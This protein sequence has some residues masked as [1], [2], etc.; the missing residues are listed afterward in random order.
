MSGT[1]TPRSSTPP[2]PRDAAVTP[3]YPQPTRQSATWTCCA[4]GG[5]CGAP[6]PEDVIEREA[7]RLATLSIY[8][9]PKPY[10]RRA[11][12][13]EPT[14]V[15]VYLN[16][17]HL[18]DISK[19]RTLKS[20]GLG[21]FHS[22]VQVMDDE[23]SFGAP[24]NPDEPSGIFLVPPMEA[25]GVLHCHLYL[26]TT[27]LT[28]EQ[29]K[30]LHRRISVEWAAADYHV[31][32]RN[33]NHFCAQFVKMLS[34]HEPLTVPNWVNRAS[35][36]FD[37]V[38]PK[39]F[40]TWFVCQATQT[41]P[42][43]A[44]RVD[45]SSNV[46]T[47]V[48]W[49]ARAEC[50]HD[51]LAMKYQQL[52][53]LKAAD[54]PSVNTGH[55][56]DADLEDDEEI[57]RLRHGVDTCDRPAPPRVVLPP[58]PPRR[59]S[60]LLRHRI[61]SVTTQRRSSAPLDVTPPGPP[62][63][64]PVPSRGETPPRAG[65]N[66]GREPPQ[67]LPDGRIVMPRP[68]GSTIPMS[69][70]HA[71]PVRLS[72]P[73]AIASPSPTRVRE[74]AAAGHRRS[75]EGKVVTFAESMESQDAP[76]LSTRTIPPPARSAS[77]PA[78]SIDFD[79][80]SVSPLIAPPPAAVAPF[81]PAATVRA[82]PVPPP[83]ASNQVSPHHP[84]SLRHAGNSLTGPTGYSRVSVDVDEEMNDYTQ[85]TASP[86]PPTLAIDR[87]TP[88]D[89]EQT[90]NFDHHQHRNGRAAAFSSGAG[91]HDDATTHSQCETA[92]QVVSGT[93]GLGVGGLA[94][95]NS[96]AGI[97][98]NNAFRADDSDDADD[99]ELPTVTEGLGSARRGSVPVERIRR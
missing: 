31:T 42:P 84:R 14:A 63:P 95:T 12:A 70:I 21:V 41:E 48:R 22:G 60:E 67:R 77:P 93:T 13:P 69:P 17:Y 50:H 19:N 53:Q 2:L 29:I 37:V 26:G 54:R 59:P 94:Y 73:G 38:L 3:M 36:W 11:D 47:D 15:P 30:T 81:A 83:T 10:S 24:A 75:V 66:T 97:T 85:R 20:V 7:E 6:R 57:R 45:H 16:V 1:H 71:D 35:N 86:G 98:E 52:G 87:A 56:R 76:S 46:G 58:P 49:A 79:G 88:V 43:K 28:R 72:A 99:D 64:S 5:C 55:D 82:G 61:A 34:T 25:L 96:T 51:P 44:V 74:D 40:A 32:N 18:V 62:R 8:R 39:R 9:N 65:N 23:W 78:L 90:Y 91:G 4:P 89:D 80:E 33:C 92:A 27:T 68:G